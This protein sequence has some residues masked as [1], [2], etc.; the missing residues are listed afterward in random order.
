MTNVL[1]RLKSKTI[2]IVED[3]AIIRNNIAST[4]KHFFKDVFT[5]FDGMDGLEKYE[6]NLPDIIMTD[7]KMPNMSGF[8]MIS[9][10]RARDCKSYTIIVSAHTDTELL[11]DAIHN[12]VDRYIVK[13]VMEDDLFSAF[14]A[15]TEKVDKTL[16]KITNLDEVTQ[17]DID[18]GEILKEGEIFSLNKKEIFLLKLMLPDESKTFTYEEIEYHVWGEKSMSLAAIRTLVRDL[19]KKLG[20]EFLQNVSGIG[21]RLK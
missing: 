21:Y 10:L 7:L 5:A 14:K 3:E 17:I 19:R 12:G 16:P 4:M 8:E 15:Y 1:S 20:T 9:E 13:P 6:A 2:L 18:K 11:L